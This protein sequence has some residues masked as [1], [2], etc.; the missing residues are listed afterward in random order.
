MPSDSQILATLQQAAQEVGLE[1]RATT[2]VEALRAE[3]RTRIRQW[4]HEGRA[5][6]MDYLAAAAPLLEDPR[7]WK[8]WAQSMVLVALPYAREAGSFRGGGRVARYALGR[9][10]HNLIGK[11]L[12]R[13]GKR[14]RAAG[15]VDR[16]RACIDAAPLAER[17]W[18]I[19]A[20]T[21]WRGKN[22]LL[23]DPDFGPWVLLGE[24]LVDAPLPDYRKPVRRWASCGSCTRCLDI[25]PTGA[26]DAAWSLDARLCLSYLTIELRGAIPHEL[27]PA[28]G[29]WV[30]GCDLCLEVCPFGDHAGEHDAEWGRLPALDELRLEDLLGLDEARFA[31]HFQG[32]PLRRPG[33]AGLARNA[34]VAL[35]NLGRGEAEL[36]LALEQDPAALVRGHAAW[37]LGRLDARAALEAAWAKEQDAEVRDEIDRALAEARGG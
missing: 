3:V 30:F 22:T 17:E 16:F 28:L 21:G 12:E 25:C 35:G 26:L 10:Y 29:E 11:R 33:R 18:A 5:G 6:E 31:A 8:D 23:L 2:P 1:V 34:C 32:S 19:Q 15:L 24:L 7:A 20:Q 27:R 36:S 13:L 9:D 14:L 37:A 4:M